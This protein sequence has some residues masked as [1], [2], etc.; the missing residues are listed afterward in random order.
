MVLDP[1]EATTDPVAIHLPLPLL[2][3]PHAHLPPMIAII[4]IKYSNTCRVNPC[5][6]RFPAERRNKCAEPQNESIARNAVKL[7]MHTGLS[8]GPAVEKDAI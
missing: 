5:T 6:K 2:P 7:G 8:A 1:E 3:L 4:A